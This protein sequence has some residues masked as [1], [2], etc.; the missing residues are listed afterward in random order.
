MNR[1]HV[2]PGHEKRSAIE[3][4]MV[5][6]G[7]ES[8]QKKW[9]GDISG[10]AIVGRVVGCD[11]EMRRKAGEQRRV[12]GRCYQHVLVPLIYFCKRLDEVAD[13]SAD[14]EIANAPRVNDNLEHTRR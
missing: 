13:V 1:D 8:A 12:G 5:H 7:G 6:V 10:G 2:R 9:E 3:W 11:C 4:N 14:A